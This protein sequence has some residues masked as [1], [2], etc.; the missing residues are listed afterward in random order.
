MNVHNFADV[1]EELGR[2][3]RA[4]VRYQVLRRTI[5][6]H[7]RIQEVPCNFRGGYP[8]GR[9]SFRKLSEPVR[10]NKELLVSSWSPYERTQY[11]DA[12]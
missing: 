6:K 12:H 8:L 5:G 9:D 10:N 2:K 11:V 1:L 3:A 7:P 4:I